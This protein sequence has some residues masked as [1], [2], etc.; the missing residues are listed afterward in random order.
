M[1]EGL[2]TEP[3]WEEAR[4]SQHTEVLQVVASGGP[5]NP[6]LLAALLHALKPVQAVSL[7]SS[8]QQGMSGHTHKLLMF[9][10]PKTKKSNPSGTFPESSS[11]NSHEITPNS[12]QGWLPAVSASGERKEP[13]T[14]PRLLGIS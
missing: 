10:Q 12:A 7:L 13:A 11:Y 4:L 2:E 8:G 9:W 3:T 1:S 6:A 5:G 14:L